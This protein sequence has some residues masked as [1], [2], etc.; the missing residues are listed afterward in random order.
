M[1][2]TNSLR[3]LPTT[4]EGFESVQQWF[5]QLRKKANSME[6]GSIPISTRV[7]AIT[8]ISKFT[9]FAGMN[10]DQLIADAQNEMKT[11]G[12][13]RKHNVLLDK[14]WETE[15]GTSTATGQFAYIKSFYRHND[16]PLTVS[17]PP[18][19]PSK[20]KERRIESSEIRRIC[21]VAPLRHSSW[22]LANSYM[23]LRVGAIPELTVE[24][25][26]VDGWK[27]NKPIYPVT[28]RKIISG[29]FDYT[30][31]IGQDAKNKLQSFFEEQG[32]KPQDCPWQMHRDYL[33]NRFKLYAYKAGVI[34]APEGLDVNEEV[35]KGLCPLRP[36]AFRKRLQTILEGAHIPLNWVDHMLGHIPRGAQASAYSQPQEQELYD[37]YLLALPKLEIYGSYSKPNIELQKLVMREQAKHWDLTEEQ[38]K[39]LENALAKI[40]DEKEME[41]ALQ[42]IMVY[43][44]RQ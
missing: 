8:A 9:A 23:G 35:P 42:N 2:N 19:P 18:Y 30:V 12:T 17:Q 40:H 29:T 37:S 11:N 5:R 38:M 39:G 14:F 26:H 28:I 41:D 31:F 34:D 21:E 33:I 16:I 36:H 24:D 1:E 6:S 10:P 44:R 43:T 25:F 22:L 32:F 15:K 13:I 20:R 7:Q 4:L 27:E 3:V